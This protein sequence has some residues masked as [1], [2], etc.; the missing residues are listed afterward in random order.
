MWYVD[1]KKSSINL[2]KKNTKI[3][4]GFHFTHSSIIFM[5]IGSCWAFSAVAAMEGIVQIRTGKLIS[6]SEQELV[7]C[8]RDADSVGCSGG[9]KE[10]AFKYVVKSKGINTE[11]GYPYQGV[12]E[13]CNITKEAVGAAHITGYEMLPA[14][15]EE[16]LLNA[17]TKQPIAVSIDAGSMAFQ[18]Y[19]DGVFTGECG[20]DLNHDVIV[21]GYG[22]NADGMKYWL[23]KNSWGPFWGDGGYIMIERDVGDKE[24]M[25]GIAMES[26]YPTLKSGADSN[27]KTSILFVFLLVS[28][29]NS[30]VPL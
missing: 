23:V 19:S 10:D 14:N 16:A 17:L 6:L 3:L 22:T 12:D 29:V 5:A 2:K 13:S 25:C 7:D 28:F 11:D 9:N 1:K 21:V 26:S 30:F 20:R 15:N 27:L 4:S 18:L 24:G 8:N